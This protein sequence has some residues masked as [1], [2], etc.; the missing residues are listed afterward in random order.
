LRGAGGALL[1][2]EDAEVAE[3]QAIAAAQFPDGL[4]EEGL[5]DLL[6]DD[7]LGVGLVGDAVNKLFLRNRVHK[8][9]L[10]GRRLEDECPGGDENELAGYRCDKTTYTALGGIFKQEKTVPPTRRRG[11][12]TDKAGCRPHQTDQASL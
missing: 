3:L 4:I 1:D 7:A 2:L 9:F 6:D 10:F 8:V 5:H 11:T 12:V